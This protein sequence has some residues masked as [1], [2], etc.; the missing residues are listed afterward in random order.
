MT[1]STPTSNKFLRQ[2]G[3]RILRGS[4][5]SKKLYAKLSTQTPSSSS[6]A[7]N[8][9]PPGRSAKTLLL[10]LYVDF[11]RY[12]YPPMYGCTSQ[13]H[14]HLPQIIDSGPSTG[15]AILILSYLYYLSSS[16]LGQT[17]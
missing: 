11:L 7:L 1:Y 15:L 9:P 2:E 3:G 5:L 14:P 6:L 13:I 12:I 10:N 8:A 4:R 16:K 17:S